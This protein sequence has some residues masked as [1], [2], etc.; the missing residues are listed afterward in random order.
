MSYPRLLDVSHHNGTINWTKV[1]AAGY[2]Y[3][4]IRAGYGDGNLDRQYNNNIK[5]AIKAGML[6]GI[7]WFS[8]AWNVQMAKKEG[9]AVYDLI[10]NY[11]I[12]LPVFFDWEYD[13]EKKAKAHGVK[14]SKS[15]MT[16]MT[17]AFCEYL[18]ERG[19]RVGYYYN[20][21]YENRGVIDHKKF[22]SL[23]Y[24][25]WLARYSSTPQTDC[26]IWQYAE[27]G[28]VNGIPSR[29]VDMNKVINMKVI[30]DTYED[31]LKRIKKTDNKKTEVVTENKIPTPVTSTNDTN[32]TTNKYDRTQFIKDLQK[33]FG[34]K[35]SGIATNNLLNAT[36]TVSARTN[37][38]HKCV[39]PIQKYLKSLGY[40]EVGTVDGEAGSK[41]SK[42]VKN[43][44]RKVVKLSNPDGIIT[45]KEKTWKKL[46]GL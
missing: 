41:F 5:N 8:Y 27:Y 39:R 36:V 45:K 26:D 46:L 22:A 12:S 25:K 44:Q 29:A 31:F 14:I 18:K 43:Y 28:S 10:K 17:I 42:A 16:D 2:N 23:G 6:V 13:S 4:I 33:I 38:K 34:L 19:Y 37:N 1:K 7:Y 30:T 9:A 3:A 35:E 20:R 32:T 40:T 24:Y 11:K 15:L 21:D